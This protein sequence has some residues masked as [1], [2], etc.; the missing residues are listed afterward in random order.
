MGVAWLTAEPKF[1]LLEPGLQILAT[2]AFLGAVALFWA[3]RLRTAGGVWLASA[4]TL[5]VLGEWFFFDPI[6]QR[7]HGVY[8]SFLPGVE[9]GL[10]W[11]RALAVL[12]TGSVLFFLYARRRLRRPELMIS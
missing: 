1:P 3:V 9:A 5:A 12:A 8:G 10:P 2:S 4:V 6:P 11:L 7:L